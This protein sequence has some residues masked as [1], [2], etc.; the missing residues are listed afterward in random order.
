MPAPEGQ[1]A[2]HT[3]VGSITFKQELGDPKA[4]VSVSF[5]LGHVDKA[6]A[7]TAGHAFYVASLPSRYTCSEYAATVFNPTLAKGTGV[8]GAL[9]D[10]HGTLELPSKRFL[11]DTSISL[12]GLA[13]IVGRY[14]IIYEPAAPGSLPGS[15]QVPFA[16]GA[17]HEVVPRTAV[18]T[19]DA[20]GVHGHVTMMQ[21]APDAPTEVY[22]LRAVRFHPDGRQFDFVWLPARTPHGG[23]SY[24]W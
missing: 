2:K 24:V 8:A 16:C 13:S 20:D 19:V 10:R 14:V 9:S 18:A 6:A 4:P 11:V 17:V 5:D 22:A 1:A 23:A 7:P 3:L 12:Q 15:T 21:D